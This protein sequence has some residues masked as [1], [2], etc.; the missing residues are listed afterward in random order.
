MYLAAWRVC[1]TE[2][3]AALL[4]LTKFR[5]AGVKA[6]PVE[7][8]ESEVPDSLKH[9]IP[10]AKVW[11]IGDDLLRDV[12]ARAADPDALRELKT[13]VLAVDDEFDRWL[14]SPE[15]LATISRAYVAFTSLRMV[16][17]AV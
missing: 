13:A 14:L 16:A 9:L 4:A 17:D 2:R 8:D 5:H 1:A 15:A 3:P 7:F 6:E 11:G 10:L 12:M